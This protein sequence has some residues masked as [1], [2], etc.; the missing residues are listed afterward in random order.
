MKSFDDELRANG[1][2][3]NFDELMHI[4]VERKSGRYPWGSGENPNQRSVTFL[5]TIDELK[6]KGLT[7]KQIAD[8]MGLG[9]TTQLRALKTR[10][11]AEKRAADM[12]EANR[13]RNEEQMSNV[14]IGK[15]MGINESSVRALL[16]EG[17]QARN[18]ELFQIADMLKD[19]V[20]RKGMIDI[21]EGTENLIGVSQTKLNTAVAMLE[22]DGYH[23]HRM[24]V[25]QQGT[26]KM[27]T[28]KVLAKP[29]I[30][31]GEAVK[32]RD[33][34]QTIDSAFDRETGEVIKVKPPEMLSSK[35]VK[36][37]YAEEGGADK[38]GT[39]ELRRGVEDLSLGNNKYA[40]VRIAVD[41]THYLKGMAVYS[42][43]MPDGVDVVFNTNK[44]DTGNKLKAMKEMNRNKETGDLDIENPFGATIKP[45]GQRG[46]LNIV[47]EEGD[48]GN[49]SK[50]LSSQMLSKQP[51][52]LIKQQLD[53]KLKSKLDEFDEINN[54]TNPIVKKKLLES[55]ADDAESSAVHL[56]AASLPRQGTHVILPINSLK[57]TEIYA[58][59]YK[60]GETVVLVRFPHGGIF[61]IPELKVN[62]RNK[63]ALGFLK[64]AK[65]AVGIN[66]RI[67]ER[68]SGADFDGDT[69]LV[70]PNNNR[71]VKSK[72]PLAALKDFDPKK[73]YPK[74]EGMPKMSSE[75]KQAEMGKVSNLITDMTIG[76]ATDSEIA[77]AVKH[78]MVVI[79]AEKHELNYKQSAK[80]NNIAELKRKYQG[81][82]NAG[83]STI[84]SLAS[85]EARVGQRKDRPM[86]KGGPYDKKTGE[87]VYEY[88]GKTYTRVT[89]GKD[90]IDKKTGEV[91]PGKVKE[92]L[93]PATTKSTKMAETSDARSLIGPQ[94]DPIEFAYADH[95]NALKALAR[96]TRLEFF[97][98][99]DSTYSPAANKAYKTEVASL[100]A[101]L[102]AARRNKPFERQAQLL[103][104]ANVKARRLANPDMDKAELKKIK[105]IALTNA[106]LAVG[107]EKTP[108]VIS[109]KE[110]TAIQAGA[111]SNTKLSDIMKNSDMDHI[112]SLAM[113]RD[114]PVMTDSKI[115]LAKARLKS[116][117]TLA[118]VAESLG[119]PTSTLIDAVG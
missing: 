62:N 44:S 69:V 65:D 101:K 19:N 88:S 29:E 9:S 90:R 95:A 102:A 70:I 37:R 66:S 104:E 92:E 98:T 112:K 106:R 15:K 16:D 63:E 35:R 93:V 79:D 100:D 85:S 96:K 75:T 22:E 43:N 45:G 2:F 52:P 113:P 40:Q 46:K 59:K 30:T 109:D 115:A 107:A 10:A 91:I 67:A 41:G 99:Q 84:V 68:L 24:E 114:R 7:E 47:N 86:S 83:A 53:L 27:T 58:P 55:F 13:L 23:R 94:K 1:I 80:D 36:V 56:K 118:E 105:G 57:D 3:D 61:E 76:G 26:G 31:W 54:L 14:A 110:W 51:L 28:M 71:A 20:D 60:N 119:V 4:G 87:R 12:T 8:G 82:A 72:P 25:P 11:K 111:I 32:N 5:S 17:A 78:S 103:A 21:G 81:G 77:R 49:W 18:D 42:D 33:N 64:D 74:Y 89:V 116:G 108:I 34:I 97:K 50:S 48:W 6:K 39:I 38:D 73:Q 117:N